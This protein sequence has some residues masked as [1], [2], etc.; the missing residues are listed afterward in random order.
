MAKITPKT[1]IERHNSFPEATEQ[2]IEY[3]AN[4]KI[5]DHVQQLIRYSAVSHVP[6]NNVVVIVS[7]YE[8]WDKFKDISPFKGIDIKLLEMS[9]KINKQT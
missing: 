1:I 3:Y 5:Q 2:L 7:D 4:M 8:F 9:D 6:T